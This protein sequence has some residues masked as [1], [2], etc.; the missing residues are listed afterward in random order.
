[1][2]IYDISREAGVS[3]ATVSRVLNNSPHVSESTRQ[4][5][6]KVIEKAGYVPN[7]F[8]RGLGLNTM[9]TIGLVCPDAANPY[10]ANAMTWL[11]RS[12]RARNYNCLLACTGRGDYSAQLEGV[13]MLCNRHVDG[14]VLMGSSFVCEQEK[15]NA[16]LHEAAKHAPLI[17]L[18]GAYIHEN[19]YCV[20][21]DDRHGTMDATEHLIRSGRKKI[22]YLY[23]STNFSAKRKMEGYKDA[24]KKN[25]IP[26]DD[27][28]MLFFER[29]SR[30]VQ[31]VRDRLLALAEEGLEF[32]AVVGAEDVLAVGA[33]KYAHAR[34]LSIPDELS[35]IGYND[36]DLCLCCE[37]EL[38]S[39]DN[40]LEVLCD[41]IVTTMM[42]VLEG[43]EM[44][45]STVFT[46]EI[47]YRGSTVNEK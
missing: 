22:L 30:A 8:A 10:L 33:V 7:A 5:V 43:K 12:F 32:D 9:K 38:T 16:Y 27:Q 25:H 23:N 45:Q 20:L 37:P 15:D 39:M 42:G 36:S 14:I 17:L 18:N 3:I 21:C 34:G 26:V 6:L 35:I 4:R 31:I 24:L 19:I 13:E 41:Q 11:E 40:R 44:P 46:A 29:S 47:Q 28:L 2:N 1:M